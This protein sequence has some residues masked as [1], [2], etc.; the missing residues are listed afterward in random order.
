KGF[1]LDAIREIDDPE[2]QRLVG[3]IEESNSEG[4]SR[5]YKKRYIDKQLKKFNWKIKKRLREIGEDQR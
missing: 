3:K 2:I 4:Y 5:I 1:G